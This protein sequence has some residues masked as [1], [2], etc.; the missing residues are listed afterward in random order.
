MKRATSGDAHKIYRMIVL[1]NFASETEDYQEMLRKEANKDVFFNTKAKMIALHDLIEKGFAPPN[2]IVHPR[3]WTLR[4]QGDDV[5]MN[6]GT[7]SVPK[8]LAKG[9]LGS[10]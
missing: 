4:A 10:R 2:S 9:Q 3:L 5:I 1:H 8:S 7:P 6:L